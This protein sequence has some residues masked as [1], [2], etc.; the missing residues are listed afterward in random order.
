[1]VQVEQAAAAAGQQA[2]QAAA[3]HTSWQAAELLAEQAWRASEE[4]AASMRHW[5]G[6]VERAKVK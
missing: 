6:E 4:A 5:Q 1:M 2:A 3:Q